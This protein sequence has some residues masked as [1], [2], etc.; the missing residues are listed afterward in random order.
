[1]SG[2]ATK[3]ERMGEELVIGRRSEH[4]GAGK[5]RA[6]IPGIALFSLAILALLQSLSAAEIDEFKLPPPS[7]TQVDFARD[8][9]PIFQAEC[10]RCHSGE[11]PKSNYRLTSREEA[12]KGGNDGVDIL[13]GQSA[14]SPLIHYVARLIPD[15][16]MPP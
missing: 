3:R 14:R 2:S 4:S 6:I 11:R 7:D 10:L 16:E 8:I 1:M 15:L 9:K 5:S 13:P 12:L